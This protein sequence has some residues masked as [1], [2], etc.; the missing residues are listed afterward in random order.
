MASMYSQE[1]FHQR[2]AAWD[3]DGDGKIGLA[4]I[5]RNLQVLSAAGEPSVVP[6]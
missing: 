4:D 3:V 5:I 6:Q 2:V 1:E